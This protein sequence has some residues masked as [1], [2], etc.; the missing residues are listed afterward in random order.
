MLSTVDISGDVVIL[1]IGVDILGR[2]SPGRVRVLEVAKVDLLILGDALARFVGKRLL[3]SLSLFDKEAV[4]GP[5]LEFAARGCC[6]TDAGV[7]KAETALIEKN[8]S[9]WVSI[10]VFI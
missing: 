4:V 6:R 10:Q 8:F 3:F 9:K 2:R 1:A 7:L 5:G